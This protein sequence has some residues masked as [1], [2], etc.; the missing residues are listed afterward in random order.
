MK[1]GLSRREFLRNLPAVITVG[2]VSLVG[3]SENKHLK[4][5]QELARDQGEQARLI[6]NHEARIRLLEGQPV[7]P[8]VPIQPKQI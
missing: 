3:Y 8:L 1:E 7:T 6:L 5:T 4:T 2:A